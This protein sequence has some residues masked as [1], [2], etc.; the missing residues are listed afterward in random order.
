[1]ILT[2]CDFVDVD[3]FVVDIIV[4]DV[5]AFDVFV[6][7]V[8][9]V[10]IVV[11]D[12]L[13]DFVVDV[14]VIGVVVVDIIVFVSVVIGLAVFVF[15]FSL[16]LEVCLL[17]CG[18][19]NDSKA[20]IAVKVEPYAIHGSFLKLEYLKTEFNKDSD[21]YAIVKVTSHSYRIMVN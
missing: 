9:V 2:I 15:V 6:I 3:A 5:V 19:C 14:V 21:T 7:D 18:S 11:I 17:C 13:I 8:V 10:D 20:L 16:L 4:I 12:V 1:M